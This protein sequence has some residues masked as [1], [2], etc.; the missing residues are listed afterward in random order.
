VVFA[1]KMFDKIKIDDSVVT[2]L[3]HLVNGI[4]DTLAIGI[5][6]PD[7]ALFAQIKRIVVIGIFAFL[8]SLVVWA[9]LK[10]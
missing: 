6:N 4:W 3:V 9:V 10:N 2:L 1:V 5:F 7:V 8:S